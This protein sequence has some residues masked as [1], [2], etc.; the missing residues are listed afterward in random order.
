[1]VMDLERKMCKEGRRSLGFLVQPKEEETDGRPHSSLQLLM[2][3]AEEQVDEAEELLMTAT[4][5]EGTA[6][7]SVRE[8]SV[9]VLG[10]GSSPKHG[11]ALE[12]GS[13]A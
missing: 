10:K 8:G 2:R 11:C 12:Q 13:V 5:L 7:S 6:W 9:W 3:G 1:M 4:G